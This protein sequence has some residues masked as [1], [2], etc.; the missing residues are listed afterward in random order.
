[1]RL[2]TKVLIINSVSFFVLFGLLMYISNLYIVRNILQQENSELKNRIELVNRLITDTIDSLNRTTADWGQWDEM[3][4]FV[5][6][7]TQE[8]ID[9]NFDLETI[10]NLELNL[11]V[12]VNEGKVLA[13]KTYDYA[14][15]QTLDETGTISDLNRYIPRLDEVKDQNDL[16]SGIIILNNK[17][18][19]IS[20]RPITDS[21]REQPKAGILIMGRYLDRN[22]TDYIERLSKG[23]ITIE[24][25]G[26]YKGVIGDSFNKESTEIVPLANNTIKIHYYMN[27]LLADKS[28]SI[29]LTSYRNIY[30]QGRKF[31]D[32]FTAF[33]IGSLLIVSILSLISLRRSI[34]KPLEKINAEINLIDIKNKLDNRIDVKGNDEFAF[35]ATEINS[36]L[37]R[38]DNANQ[39]VINSENKLKIVMD[40]ASAGYWDWDIK[41][42]TLMVNSRVAEML[43]LGDAD[44]IASPKEWQELIHQEDKAYAIKVLS[45]SQ[46]NTSSAIFLE[47][48]LLTKHQGYKWFLLQ[49]KKVIQNGSESAKLMGII[50]DITDKKEFEEELKYLTYYDTLTGL[51][52]RGYFEV[53]LRNL[54]KKANLPITIMLADVNGLKLINDTFSYAVGDKLLVEVSRMLEKACGQ[55]SIIS[56]LGGDEFAI[57]LEGRD[58][59]TVKELFETIKELGNQMQVNSLSISIALGYAMKYFEEDDLNETAKIA[60]ERMY[61]NKL[62]EKRSSRNSTISSLSKMLFEKSYETEEHALR[63]YKICEKIGKRLSMTS[64]QL[65]ELNLLAKLHDIGKIAIPDQILNKPGKLTEDE[66]E[67]MKTHTKIGYKIATELEDLRHVAYQ[68]LCHH[69]NF[70]G[71]GYPNGLKDNSI[72][73]LSRIIRIVDSFDVMVSGR[74][75]KTPMTKEEAMGELL[76]CSGKHYDPELIKLFVEVYEEYDTVEASLGE[77]D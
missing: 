47:H 46:V 29:N 55:N 60:E 76:R 16:I 27:D 39:K 25:V 14:E 44:F 62:L 71:S 51:F 63:M 12:V 21:K 34:I 5:L 68:I 33:Y 17:P 65:D 10:S 69:E 50:T 1:M 73:F 26:E 56:R 74:P 53:S 61:R 19:L 22:V 40:A 72:P 11:I 6:E 4:E 3:Y 57:I 52:N 54:N 13:Y 9:G 35:L 30:S 24:E 23:A 37:E 49:G 18:M 38:I 41:S 67:I 77:D 7:P 59:T 28:F 75:Y 32:F 70:D 48:R 8:F 15:K 42:N 43:G 20:T 58:T 31:V 36:M 45:N 66:F 2:K 64:A